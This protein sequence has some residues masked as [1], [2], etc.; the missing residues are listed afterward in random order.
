MK[1]PLPAGLPGVAV[2]A[3]VLVL[4][5]WLLNRVSGVAAGVLDATGGLVTGEGALTRNATD[6]AGRPVAAYR[7]AGVL[8]TVGAAT[9]AASGGVLASVG[10]WLGGAAYDWT[11]PS[12]AAQSA[13]VL[14]ASGAQRL[15]LPD[16]WPVG[17]G[18][19]TSWAGLDP[20]GRPL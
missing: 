16:T 17:E 9:N 15:P 5:V 2:V 14:T 8:G 12:P 6:A 4:A 7:G 1:T 13:A 20:V 18:D 10:N 11:H 19:A 3:G